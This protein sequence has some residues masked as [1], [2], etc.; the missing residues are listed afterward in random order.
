DIPKTVRS[1]REKVTAVPL[2]RDA[3]AQAE[4]ADV[5]ESA[6]EWSV[7]NL[8]SQAAAVNYTPAAREA[9]VIPMRDLPPPGRIEEAIISALVSLTRFARRKPGTSLALAAIAGFAA[10]IGLRRI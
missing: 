10:G 3:V 6:P 2:A 5:L 1:P 9:R 8:A 7:E 4:N